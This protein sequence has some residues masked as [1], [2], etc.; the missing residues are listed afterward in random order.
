MGIDHGIRP[1]LKGNTVVKTIFIVNREQR[2]RFVCCCCFFF[3]GGGEGGWN[4]PIYYGGKLS[5]VCFFPNNNTKCW[6]ELRPR[7][8][9]LWLCNQLIIVIPLHV[10]LYVEIIHELWR[11]DYLTYGW[12]KMV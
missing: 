2:K 11:V 7:I 8:A 3:W 6:F 1:N 9:D 5:N 12:S 10:R 4:K